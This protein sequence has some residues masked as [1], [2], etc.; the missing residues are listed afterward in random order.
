MKKVLIAQD[1]YQALPRGPDDLSRHLCPRRTGKKEKAC[2]LV[3]PGERL[4]R[5]HEHARGTEVPHAESE[6]SVLGVSV[7]GCPEL[8]SPAME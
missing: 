7:D 4:F 6:H 2:Y 5:F 3:A 8:R 1:I